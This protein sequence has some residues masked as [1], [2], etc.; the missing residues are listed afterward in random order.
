[1]IKG[2]CGLRFIRHFMQWGT[3]EDLEEYTQ[4][5]HAFARLSDTSSP[6]PAGE[7]GP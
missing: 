2:R 1:M 4:W 6:S 7:A 5:S 3:P